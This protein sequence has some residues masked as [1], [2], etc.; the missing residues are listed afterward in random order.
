LIA[1]AVVFRVLRIPAAAP[2]SKNAAQQCGMDIAKWGNY[3]Y[4]NYKG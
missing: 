2:A 1:E 3:F 4:N